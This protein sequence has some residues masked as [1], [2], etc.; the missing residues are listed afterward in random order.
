MDSDPP[1]D[2]R[3]AKTPAY[4]SAITGIP[5]ET[6]IALAREMGTTKPVFVAQGLGPQRRANGEETA[7]AIAML[8]I[9]LGQVGLPGTSSGME[10]CGT[11]WWPIGIP[12]GNNPVKASIPSFMW[13]EAILRGHEM[14]A[15]HDGVKG[16][17]RLKNDIKM[18]INSGGNILINQHS[19]CGRTDKI[20]RDTSKC[21]FIDRTSCSKPLKTDSRTII[22]AT[23]TATDTTLTPAIR[24]ITEWDFF[25]KK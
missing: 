12:R 21:E 15:T 1:G 19:D 5:E 24:L 3:V 22:A 2:R 9:L 6:I 10:E 13:T 8:P 7:R 4:A 14:T 23:G 11:D 18:V 16:V 17:D 20:L 25:E